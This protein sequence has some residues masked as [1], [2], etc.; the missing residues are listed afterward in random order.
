MCKKQRVLIHIQRQISSHLLQAR[1]YAAR[2]NYN[3]GKKYPIQIENWLESEPVLIIFKGDEIKPENVR[4]SRQNI[5]RMEYYDDGSGVK[6]DE[7]IEPEDWFVGAVGF[8]DDEYSYHAIDEV[9][10]WRPVD[11]LI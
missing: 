3:I 8:G 1:I 10:A 6:L 4:L 5:L 2:R 9:L 7:E 11:D